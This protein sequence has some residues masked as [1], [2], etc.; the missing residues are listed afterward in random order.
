MASNAHL[1]TIWGTWSASSCRCSSLACAVGDP[2]HGRY[3]YASW[4]PVSRTRPM[5]RLHHHSSASRCLLLPQPRRRRSEA[6]A[7]RSQQDSSSRRQM[8]APLEASSGHALHDRANSL[9]RGL[10]GRCSGIIAALPTSACMHPAAAALLHHFCALAPT[11]ACYTDTSAPLHVFCLPSSPAAPPFVPAQD[12]PSRLRQGLVE[13]QTYSAGT[14]T[15]PATLKLE[16]SLLVRLRS[17]LSIH[18]SL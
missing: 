8:A 18:A 5:Q 4:Q 14:T 3:R 9:G 12:C 15:R 16:V 7:D 11:V 10:I 13:R 1:L 2:R 17:E 6:S